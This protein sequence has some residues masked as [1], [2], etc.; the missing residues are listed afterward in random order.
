MKHTTLRSDLVNIL[1]N[2]KNVYVDKSRISG[3]SIT[4]KYLND[5]CTSTYCYN[6]DYKE[7]DEDILI[8]NTLLE[9]KSKLLK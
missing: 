6:S 1:E 2:P 7:R 5:G 9:A 4:V 3:N 8:I